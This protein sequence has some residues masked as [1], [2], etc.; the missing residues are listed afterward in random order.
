M[1]TLFWTP[2]IHPHH[3]MGSGDI[4]ST[5]KDIRRGKEMPRLARPTGK[6][7]VSRAEKVSSFSERHSCWKSQAKGIMQV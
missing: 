7:V 3:S 4:S 1:Q 6:A 2:F 5:R